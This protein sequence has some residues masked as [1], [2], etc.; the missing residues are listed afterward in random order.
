MS[1]G[2]HRAGNTL[3]RMPFGPVDPA[4]DL[5]ALEDRVARPLA[6][7]RHPGPGQPAP[8]GRRAVDLLR[9]PAHRQ[10]PARPPPRVG[11]GVQGP[12]PPLPDHAGP[13]AS[14]ARAAGT[15]TA[16]RSSSRSRRSSASTRSTRSRPTASPSSTSAAASR[17]SRYVEDWTSLTV[18][19]GRL[20]RHRRRLLDARQRLRRVG[21]VAGPPDV[22]PGPA[23]RGPP[24]R[25]LLRPLRHRALARTRSPRATGTSS[26][27]RSTSASPITDGPTAPVGADLLVWTTT[28]WTLVSNVGAAVGP[29]IAYVR[30]RRPG[31][32]CATS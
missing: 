29:D 6:G 32:R 27:R 23:L 17:C 26:T 5:V 14:P 9:G 16:C 8:Q 13:A 20:D 2:W 1:V 15:A 24:G 21:L 28:P 4:L 3:P 18:A 7:R 10:R 30:H 25:P 31:R 22:G 11:P 12:L 19:L